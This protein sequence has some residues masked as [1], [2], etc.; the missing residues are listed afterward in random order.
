[1]GQAYPNQKKDPEKNAQICEERGGIYDYERNKC[2][3]VGNDS[4]LKS[5]PPRQLK[6]NVYPK[7]FNKFR[8]CINENF[9]KGSYFSVT[10]VAEECET[11]FRTAK[12]YLKLLVYKE[13]DYGKIIPIKIGKKLKCYHDPPDEII[14]VLENVSRE[15]CEEK[16]G[17]YDDEQMACIIPEESESNE[18]PEKFSFLD[19]NKT[20]IRYRKNLDFN[21]GGRNVVDSINVRGYRPDYKVLLSQPK[22]LPNHT[23]FSLNSTKSATDVVNGWRGSILEQV[24]RFGHPSEAYYQNSKSFELSRDPVLLSEIDRYERTDVDIILMVLV[25]IIAAIAV[26]L[27]FA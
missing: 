20:D 16:G 21:L 10:E 1:M 12:K 9:P 26:I 3:S 11:D 14:L 24:T 13:L 2:V 5:F 22:L 27:F 8:E 7:P 23:Y 25:L 6:P 19:K 18:M 4:E 17:I 15:M